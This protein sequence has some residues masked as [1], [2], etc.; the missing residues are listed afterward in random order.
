MRDPETIERELAAARGDLQHELGELK[1]IVRDKL[2][3]KQRVRQAVRRGAQELRDLA[4]RARAGAKEHPGTALALL[5]G[6]TLLVGAVVFARRHRRAPS[7]APLGR[8]GDE[9]QGIT[10]EIAGW[11]CG[12]AERSSVGSGLSSGALV[13]RRTSRMAGSRS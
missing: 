9:A 5:T 1:D 2:D 10:G 8:G 13:S 4:R 3:V 12:S 11:F 7:R 6:L